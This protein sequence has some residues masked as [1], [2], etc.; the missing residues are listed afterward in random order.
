[1]HRPLSFPLSQTQ[2][3]PGMGSTI[4]FVRSVIET[5]EY[6]RLISVAF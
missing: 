5:S 6:D 2:N 4:P 1:M 3:V